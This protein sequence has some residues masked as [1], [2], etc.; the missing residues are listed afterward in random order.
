MRHEP[1]KLWIERTNPRVDDPSKYVGPDDFP[2][3]EHPS[4]LNFY[5]P[6]QRFNPAKPIPRALLE[7][8]KS[9]S[10]SRKKREDFWVYRQEVNQLRASLGNVS[11]DEHFEQEWGKVNKSDDETGDNSSC[12]D[13][14]LEVA[15]QQEFGIINIEG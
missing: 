2:V 3:M 7:N 13:L 15:T 10:W 11:L 9:L 12:G 8:M 14:S 1:R 5:S 6:I 4:W